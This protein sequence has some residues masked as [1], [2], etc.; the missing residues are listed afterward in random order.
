MSEISVKT[1]S[2]VSLGCPKNLVDS[3][4]YVQEMK[5][6]GFEFRPELDGCETVI[7]NTCGFLR[8]ARDEARKYLDALIELKNQGH[9]RRI[10][11]RGCMPKFEGIK[12][13]ATE[14]PDVDEWFGVPNNATSK[15]VSFK[16][17]EILTK[18][19]VAYLR[20]ADGC[21][22][23][24]TFCAIPNIRGVFRS[25]PMESLLEEARQLA[26]A[27][28]REL[29][30][31]AQETTF[32]GTDL[33][34]KP[35]LPRLLR[36]LE[37]IEGIRWIRVMYAYPQFFDDE[38]IELF[39][40]GGKGKGK[41]LPYIDIP[42]QHAADDILHRMNRRVTKAET[43]K[44][45]E[46]LREQIDHLVLRTSL[47]VGFPGETDTLFGELLKFVETWKFERAGVFPFSAEAGT[48]AA[49]FGNRV[50][51]RVIER[52]FER[53]YKV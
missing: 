4:Y 51:Q 34:G 27:G 10:V 28:V 40:A 48:P 38:L 44:L 45:L 21:D 37:Q 23:H 15:T 17:R 26:D 20:I 50:P 39:A 12:K 2:I 49:N 3:E 7:L 13:L 52:R 47:I 24:C 41:L 1:F 32:W 5:Q 9:I 36:E 29:I 22:R 42:L 46:K 14:F 19:H 31:I 18:K 16:R 30:V 8:S 11:V 43:E 53:L 25:E 6:A 35:Q 33:Y